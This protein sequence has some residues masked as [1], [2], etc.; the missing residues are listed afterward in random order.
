MQFVVGD[1]HVAMR[2]KNEMNV[3]NVVNVNE[4]KERW[5]KSDCETNKNEKGKKSEADEGEK[6]ENVRG[7]GWG[8][9]I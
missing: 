7:R 1:V 4:S 2:C 3:L 8:A 9:K 5:F 6:C